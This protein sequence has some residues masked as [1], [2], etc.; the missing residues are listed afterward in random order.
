MTRYDAKVLL[1]K[2][3]GKRLMFVGDSLNRNQ[4]ESMICLIHSASARDCSSLTKNGSLSVFRME[5]NEIPNSCPCT[6]KGKQKLNRSLCRIS[7]RP[8]SSTGLHSSSSRTPTILPYT[9]S[10]TASSYPSPSP[11]MPATGP[12]TTSSSTPTSGG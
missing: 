5:V 8:W 11:S 1:E 2:L 12:L 7:T 4:W 9:A 6:K 10:L 3:R